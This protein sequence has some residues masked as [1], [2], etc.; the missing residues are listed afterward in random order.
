VVLNP[1]RTDYSSLDV[2]A[3]LYGHLD[4]SDIAE[5]MIL[6]E[7]IAAISYGSN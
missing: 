3:D 4:T 7:E 6:F 5:D 1:S 2:T